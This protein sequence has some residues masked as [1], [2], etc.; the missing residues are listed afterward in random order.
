[1]EGNLLLGKNFM[2]FIVSVLLRFFTSNFFTKTL[3]Y[4]ERQ[5]KEWNYIVLKTNVIVN[6]FHFTIFS[7]PKCTKNRM[8]I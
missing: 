1:L 6:F 4:L 3:K 8:E 7:V 5:P 2:S